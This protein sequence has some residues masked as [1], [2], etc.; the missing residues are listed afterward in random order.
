MCGIFAYSGPRNVNKILIQGLKNLEYRGYDSAGIAF[1]NKGVIHRFRVCGGVKE[2]SN[3]IQS[4]SNKGGLGVGHTRWATHGS[5]SETNAHPHH[6]DTIYVVHN[7][8]IE[9]TQEIKQI[10]SADKI[11]SETDTELIAHLINHFYQSENLDF[12]E[13]IFKS[14]LFLKGSYAVVA[15]NEKKPNRNDSF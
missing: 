9:N 11:L 1:F 2:L 12:L 6:S 7:G 13:S 14:V 4:F 10:I 5:P 8:V 3:K 15:I